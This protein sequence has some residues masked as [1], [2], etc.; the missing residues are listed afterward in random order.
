MFIQF[1][2]LFSIAYL[3]IASIVYVAALVFV[4][5]FFQFVS[6]FNL[7]RIA[8]IEE[9]ALPGMMALTAPIV[10]RYPFFR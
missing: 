4:K 10:Y 3:N 8:L 1:L 7:I 2:T 6:P 5:Q 9:I